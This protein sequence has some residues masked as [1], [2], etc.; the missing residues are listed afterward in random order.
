MKDLKPSEHLSGSEI[1]I[2]GMSGR[3]PGAKTIEAFWNNLR[4]GVESITFFS[5]EQLQ[6]SG[7]EPELL[8]N[9]DYVKARPVLED[10]ELFD[11]A[12]FGFGPGEA[13]LLDPQYRLFL[14]CV[15]EAIETAGYDVESYKGGISVYAGACMSS[16][17]I[18]NLHGNPV[19]MASG[20]GV[21]SFIF[22][23]PA[24]LTTGVA[25][26]L[27]LKGSSYTI[28]TFCSTSLVAVHI[29]CESLLNS[30]CDMAVAGGASVFVPQ[31]TGYLYQEGLIVSPDGHC[32]PF[33]AKA[34]GTVLGSGVGAV[35]LKR[36]EDALA[37]G[38]SIDAVIMGSA[39]NNDGS[40]KVSYTAPSVEGQGKVIVEALANAGVEPETITYV[41]THGTGTALGDPAEIAAL[42][43]AFRLGTRRN[44]CCAIGSVKSNIGHLD[45]AAGVASLIKA[46]LALKHRA[47]P[48]SLHF[49]APNPEIDFENSSFFVNTKLS[50]WRVDGFPRRAAVSSFG[51]GGTNAHVIV[52]EAPARDMSSASRPYQLVVL[53]AKTSSALET[54]TKNLIAYFKEHPELKLSDVA[55]TL[56]VGRKAFSHRRMFVCQDLDGALSALEDTHGARMLTVYQERRDPSVAFM[57]SGQ[58][59]QYVNMGLEL[60][61]TESEF[62][63]QIDNCS[64]ILTTHLSLDL[65][66]VLYPG[67][68]DIEKASQKLKQTSVTQ[69]ALFVI[70]YALAR[71]W[72]S[73]GIMPQALAGHSIGEY[74]AACLAGV[75]NLEDAL[76]LVA[77]RGRLIQELPGG[78]MMAV[79]L[80]EEEIEPFLAEN[81]SLA[82]IN[83]PSICTVSGKEE[84][85]LDLEKQL[86]ERHIQCRYLQTSHAFHSEMVTPI[87]ETFVEKLQKIRLHKPKLRFLSNVTGTWITPQDAVSPSYWA[88]HL[89]QTVRFSHCLQ[90]LFKEPSRVLLEVGP[91]RTLSTLARQHPK[92]SKEQIVL[93]SIRHPKEENSDVAFILDALGRLW[94]AGVN[95]HW[96]AFCSQERRHRVPLPT[97]PF[98]RKRHWIEPH[99]CSPLVKV[100]SDFSEQLTRSE[101]WDNMPQEA[102]QVSPDMVN[103]DPYDAPRSPAE[104]LLA[105]IW[106]Q[107]LGVDCVGVHDTFFDLGGNSLLS[108]AVVE[109]IRSKTGVRLGPDVILLNTL[110]DIAP[111]LSSGASSVEGNL[112]RERRQDQAGPPVRKVPEGMR[113][114]PLY[115][116]N[117]QRRLF[118]VYH[119][120]RSALSKDVGVCLCYPMPHEYM[121][122]HMAFRQLSNL[123]SKGGFPVFRFDYFGTG[124]SSGDSMEGDVSQWIGDIHTA[125]R[126]FKHTSGV[127]QVCMVG[128]RFGAALAAKATMDGINVKDLVLW[129]PVIDGQSHISE[130]KAMHSGLSDYFPIPRKELITTGNFHQLLGYPFSPQMKASIEKIN[131]LQAPHCSAETTFL[132]VSEERAEYAR[133]SDQMSAN[134]VHVEYHLVPDP[135]RWGTRA[136]LLEVQLSSKIILAI[137]NLLTQ[138]ST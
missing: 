36:L 3:F 75:F 20:G 117:P 23:N 52:Q 62:R 103:K 57:F 35:V 131:L 2:I 1:A 101:D 127:R 77:T 73:W 133:L 129:D 33:D 68:E 88:N 109:V 66:D 56:Q 69:P 67:E 87:L 119:P 15:W 37:D 126:Q 110:G 137:T 32:R 130:M 31:N 106:Q 65:R 89:R 7:V 123:L 79:P 76:L 9:P 55:Y 70:E 39:T 113:I 19:V 61:R 13:A 10:I 82:A 90:E 43:R 14:E 99:R 92:K 98:E 81:L 16:Y 105:G 118:G 114:R 21:Q 134:G 96:H 95:V 97:Y 64:E 80:S 74:V 11:A 42:T 4:D 28:H 120:P 38:D 112:K 84:A 53:S 86:S 132:V 72:M 135:A 18:N 115:F 122:M 124:D 44:G 6:A 121:T 47:I 48:P 12:F 50:E 71:L 100:E 46:V 102:E 104:V 125:V 111:A 138:N 63:Q 22:N 116:G 40:L 41:E 51:F 30:E 94:L 85:I 27:N 58:G 17:Y 8:H 34:R 136:I 54:A 128:V 83:G 78:G 26:K 59:S 91:G 93:S 25:Y 24:Y 45:A 49:E 29:A 107:V 5:D 60:Y 108:V